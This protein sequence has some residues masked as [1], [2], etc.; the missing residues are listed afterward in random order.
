MQ[1]KEFRAFTNS[2][3]ETLKLDPNDVTKLVLVV[4]P[5]HLRAKIISLKRQEGKIYLENGKLVKET[6]RLEISAQKGEG[7]CAGSS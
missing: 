7:S 6:T 5:F 2:L 1:K 4:E 3:C